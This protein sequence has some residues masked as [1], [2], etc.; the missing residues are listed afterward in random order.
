MKG[1]FF[2]LSVL[3]L[4]L[5]VQLAVIRPA[6]AETYTLER[7][8]EIAL[9]VSPTVGISRENLASSRTGVLQA[10]GGFLPNAQLSFRVGRNFAG[11]TSG[12]LF[13][14]Q[15][16]PI[17]PAGSQYDTYVLSVN[18]GMTLFN[19]GSN[20]RRLQQSQHSAEA[21]VYDLEYRKDFIKAVVIR[22]YYELVRWVK[23]RKVRDEDVALN[24]RN[25]EQVEAFYNIGSRTKADF[26]QA[27]VT[28]ANSELQMLNAQ[29]SL[30]LAQARLVSRLNMPVTTE[31]ILDDSVDIEPGDVNIQEEVNFMKAHRADLL[32]SKERV[33]AAGYNVSSLKDGRYPDLSAF[34][35]YSWNDREWRNFVSMFEEN[36]FWTLGLGLN[37]NIFDRFLTKSNVMNAEAGK[38]IAEYNLQQAEIDA[39]LDIQQIVVNLTQARERLDLA[40][41]TVTHA[42]ENV[43]LAEERYRVGAGTI[44]ETIQANASLTE[45]SASLIEAQIDYLVNRADLQRATGR[46]ISTQ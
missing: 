24:Q 29:N 30:E 5:T 22:E 21:A 43:R 20:Y 26:L 28:L 3:L 11:P 12:V 40:T 25:L 41:E 8:I 18:G 42:Q 46:P 32:G 7:C 31:L 10:Y 37:W 14:A 2:L 4:V 36:F 45:A 44:L 6:W 15:G 38:R 17:P 34:Y 23:L 13:D 33:E 9:K 1:R 16:R 27:R 35:S 39:L 19:W